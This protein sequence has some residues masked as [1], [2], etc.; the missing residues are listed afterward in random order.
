M[1]LKGKR[2]LVAGMGKSGVAA[3]EAAL[4]EGAEVLLYDKKEESEIDDQIRNIAQQNAINCFWNRIPEKEEKPDYLVLSPGIPLD[5][6]ILKYGEAV[7]A[8]DRK[9]V[10]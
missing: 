1:K 8:E 2:V 5:E 4:A 3:M 10:V 6:E 9:S 7:G